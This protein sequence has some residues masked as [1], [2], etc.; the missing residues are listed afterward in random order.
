[1]SDVKLGVG[2]R[3]MRG[4]EIENQLVQRR[5]F[6]VG[7]RVD[8][9][10]DTLA[11]GSARPHHPDRA[12]AFS[13]EVFGGACVGTVWSVVGDDEQLM[14]VVQDSLDD[15]TNWV[16]TST[17]TVME[18]LVRSFFTYRVSSWLSSSAMI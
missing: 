17:W 18:W 6:G 14:L 9:S 8:G 11:P 13:K 12:G 15:A 7:L 10:E 16:P 5:G 3:G 2:E 4:R 1:M